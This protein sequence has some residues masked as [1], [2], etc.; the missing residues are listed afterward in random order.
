MPPL[1][2]NPGRPLAKPQALIADRGYDSEPHRKQL[3]RRGIDP[4]IARRGVKHGSGLGTLRW[5][6]ER[7]VSWLHQTRRL[8]VRYE[9][10]ADLHEAFVVLRCDV[11]CWLKLQTFC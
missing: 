5:V 9:K 3:R 2:G 8:R 10:R 6:V 1:R 4:V 7:T 11:I